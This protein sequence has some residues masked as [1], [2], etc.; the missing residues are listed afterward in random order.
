MIYGKVH[1]TMRKEVWL[2]RKLLMS[3]RGMSVV[4]ALLFLVLHAAY[5]GDSFT[6]AAA[7]GQV[8]GGA[9]KP[10]FA[11][12]FGL[13]SPPTTPGAKLAEDQW[14]AGQKLDHFDPKE[15][16]TWKQRYFVNDTN[17]DGKDGP[18]FVL[19]GGEGPASPAWL[20]E[21]TEIMVNAQMNK[22]LVFSLEHR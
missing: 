8:H 17:W 2:A 7:R 10:S 21:Q 15:T 19:I 3:A 14:F 11:F 22:A 1:G 20:A 18:V 5:G 4:V 6:E 13:R 9:T 12:G 16:R